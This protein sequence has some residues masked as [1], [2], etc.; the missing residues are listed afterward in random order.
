M[1]KS[2]KKGRSKSFTGF[3]QIKTNTCCCTSQ[4][5]VNSKQLNVMGGPFINHH[6]SLPAIEIKCKPNVIDRGVNRG[7]NMEFYEANIASDINKTSLTPL[8]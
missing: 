3:D 5:D 8:V 2:C 1:N 6:K 7:R 4:N